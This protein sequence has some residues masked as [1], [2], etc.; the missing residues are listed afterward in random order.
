VRAL[1]GELLGRGREAAEERERREEME[2][3]LAET[4]Q[5]W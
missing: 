5:V 3:Q 1:Q 4:R 2:K